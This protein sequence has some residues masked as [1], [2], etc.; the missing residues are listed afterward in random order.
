MILALKVYL[1]A[2]VKDL[3]PDKDLK[4]LFLSQ[5]PCKIEGNTLPD[6]YGYLLVSGMAIDKSRIILF[7][8]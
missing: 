5:N 3:L 7:E 6:C 4:P 2:A 8:F 1:I